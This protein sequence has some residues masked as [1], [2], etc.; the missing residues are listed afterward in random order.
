MAQ[1]RDDVAGTKW[2][3]ALHRPGVAHER[4]EDGTHIVHVRPSGGKSSVIN[5]LIDEA[6][7]KASPALIAPTERKKSEN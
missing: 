7:S 3:L 2:S 6:F 5:D 1:F 4:R